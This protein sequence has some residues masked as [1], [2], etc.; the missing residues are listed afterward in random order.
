M[1]YF[2]GKG[3]DIISNDPER[4][5]RLRENS[6]LIGSELKK[7]FEGTRFAVNGSPL[8]PLQHIYYE[9]SNADEKLNSLTEKVCS[10]KKWSFSN[11][12]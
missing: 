11:V 7:A 5:A 2:L 3:L 4:L 12:N 8:S 1:E 10:Q 6:K 9:G